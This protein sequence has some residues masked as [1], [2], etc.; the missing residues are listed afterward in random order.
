MPGSMENVIPASMIL[1]PSPVVL[2]DGTYAIYGS[3]KSKYAGSY[4]GAK[5]AKIGI[6][7]IFSK[8]KGRT[9]SKEKILMDVKEDLHGSAVTLGKGICE[10]CALRHYYPD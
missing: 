5:G 3:W 6:A 10:L 2:A 8:N 1:T 9:W 4:T 7:G